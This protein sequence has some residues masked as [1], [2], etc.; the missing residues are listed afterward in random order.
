M[1]L[2]RYFHAAVAASLA[3]AAPLFAQD[4]TSKPPSIPPDSVRPLPR[5]RPTVVFD[6]VTL[7][8]L[9]VGNVL[10][11]PVLTPGVYGLVDPQA[12]SVRGG[13]TG[14]VGVYVDGA[15]VRNGQ[16]Q[17]FELLPPLRGVASLALSTGL[18]PAYLGD[19]SPGVLEIITP[20]AEGTWTG[21]VRYRADD[22]GPDLW[23]NIG[24]HRLEATAG[25]SLPLGFTGFAGFSL[26]G[27]QSLETE[28][29]RALQAK[30]QRL[31]G[32]GEHVSLTVLAGREQER[33]FPFTALYNAQNRIAA[34]TSSRVFVLDWVHQLPRVAERPSA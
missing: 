28:K 5:H 25:G 19:A 2:Q 11:L 34:R 23:R 30:I 32:K 33:E 8:R 6:S 15:L 24:F 22:A 13:L 12:F 3:A 16:R 9:P 20:T 4:S 7:R 17:D 10:Q 18:A 27:Q 26:T 21:G 29:L 31:Y 1:R 14:D